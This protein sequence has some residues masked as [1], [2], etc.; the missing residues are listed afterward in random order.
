MA[1]RR[2]LTIGISGDARGFD[3]ACEEAEAKAKGLDR[4]LAKLERQQAAQ[5]RVTTRTAAAVERF[6][7]AN[8]KASLAAHKMGLEAKR[9]AEQAERAEVRAAAAAEAAAKGILTEEKAARLAARAADQTERAALKAAEAQLAEAAAAEKLAAAERKAAQDADKQSKVTFGLRDQLGSLVATAAALSVPVGA[10]GL[11]VVGFA[12]VAA[13]AIKKVLAAQQDLGANWS[14]LDQNQRVAAV[15]VQALISQYKALAKSYEP[16]VLAQFNGLV[17]TARGLLPELGK[18]VDS[19]RQGFADF[20]T[21]VEGG[22]SRQMPR[23]LAILRGQATPALHELGTSFNETASLAVNLVQGLA[24]MGMTLLHDTNGVLTLLNALTSI[25]PRLTEFAVTAYALRAPTQALSKLWTDGAAKVSGW[26][27]KTAQ[28]EG[29]V[30]GLAKGASKAEGEVS[31]L[32]KVVGG[33]PNLYIGAAL[34]IGY[35]AT[36]LATA[37]DATD[38]LISSVR[39]E[40]SAFGNNIKGHEAAA[41]SFANLAAQTRAAQKAALQGQAVYEGSSAIDGYDAKIRKLTAAQHEEEAAARQA[42]KGEQ[43]LSS[44]YGITADQ[45]GQL[46]TAAGVDLSKGITGSSDAAVAARAKIQQYKNA[47]DAASNPTQRIAEDMKQVSNTGLLMTDRVNALND[48][49]AAYYAPAS[50]AWNATTQLKQGMGQLAAAMKKAHG[51]FS[52]NTQASQEL[53]TA[54][55]QQLTTISALYQANL[56]TKGSQAAHAAAEAQV[57]VMYA[58]AGNSKEA[59]AQVD[60]L[61]KTYQLTVGP[62][63]M[64]RAAFIAAAES[65]GRSKAAAEALWKAYQKL[66]KPVKLTADD[67]DF[68]A[69]LKAAQ[70]LKINPKTGLL[71]GKNSDYLNKW[72]HVHHLKIDPKTGRI[73]G[74]NNSYLAKWLKVHDLRIDTK[75]GR[76]TG[77]TSA[78]WSAVRSIP[79]TVG[80]RRIG[81]Y[82]VPLNSANQPGTTRHATGGLIHRAEGGPV[83]RMAGGGPSGMVVGP[84][85]GTSDSIP[86]ML[87]N[88][89][90]V[91][92]AAA[93]RTFR[94]LLDAINYGSRPVAAAMPVSGGDGAAAGPAVTQVFETQ[95]MDVH[96]LARESAR[97]L[98]WTLRG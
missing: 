82:Y 88:G 44:V 29:E 28:A 81:V 79:S 25:D 16:D 26:G 61:A 57:Q 84:G 15:S 68:L 3:A 77:D 46:A 31:K 5:E 20:S 93:T 92:N 13:P 23:L 24:P 52:G 7:K 56:Q 11:A 73:L 8:D 64:S 96:Q 90:Y 48:A 30:S 47:V 10:A 22:L 66:T 50:A 85:T 35:L 42:T 27:K 39:T 58:L 34:A 75:T 40:N 95:P 2:D 87:S 72:L 80:Y 33:S 43:Y 55:D 36:R 86:A 94:P 78:F 14:S 41:R 89:E 45:A 70:G 6:A 17:S 91:I 9:A 54:L 71:L 63:G 83:Q 32:G 12:A 62:A 38:N 60:A 76:I 59:R 21:Q 97:E 98:A 51:D 67:R 53:R 74:D 49:L 69:K 1:S 37:K 65:M 19:T 4:E 18:T